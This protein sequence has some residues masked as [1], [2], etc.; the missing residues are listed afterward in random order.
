MSQSFGKKEVEQTVA[1]KDSEAKAMKN[2][3]TVYNVG[4]RKKKITACLFYERL[5][6]CLGLKEH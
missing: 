3:T 5:C 6:F 2:E 1:F 4:S